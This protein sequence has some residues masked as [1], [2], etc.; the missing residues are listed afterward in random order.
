MSKNLK[1]AFRQTI[2][3][4]MGYL[5]I[6]VAFGLMLSDIGYHFLWAGFISIVVYAG[7]MQ[8]LMVT[9]LSGGASLLFVLMMTLFVNGRHVFYGISMIEKFRDMGKR[10]PYM[11]FSLTD[12]T[13]SLLGR[14]QVPATLDEQKVLF[15]I[16]MLNHSYWVIGSLLGGL[17]GQLGA[18]NSTGIE[19]SMTAIFLAIVVEQWGEKKNRIPILIGI[20]CSLCFLLILGAE[21]FILPSLSLTV[22][23]ILLFGNKMRKG[24]EEVYD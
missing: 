21:Q 2:P 23:I 24:G 15:Q 12:E 4:L 5:F 19:F 18:F 8:Y 22:L 3:V 10:Y 20:G 16:S 11:I 17:V 14:T 6:G 13:Y 7:S 1:F 9:L